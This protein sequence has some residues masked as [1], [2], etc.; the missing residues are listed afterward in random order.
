MTRFLLALALSALFL[1]TARAQPASAFDAASLDALFDHAPKVEV[2]LHGALLRLAASASEDDEDASAML[3]GLRSIVVRVYSLAAARDGLTDRLTSLGSSLEGSGW[4]TL[5]RVRPDDEDGDDVW[6]YVREAGDVFDGMAVMSL[7]HDGGD[8]SFVLI[9][10][11]ID[12]SQVGHLGSR[13]GGVDIEAQDAAEEA[14]QEAHED[15]E[16]AHEEMEALQDSMQVTMDEAMEEA[17]VEMEA[18]R[19][20]MEAARERMERA[21]R[22]AVDRAQEEARAAKP[23]RGQAGRKP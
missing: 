22:D 2:N 15:M 21:R 16:E 12:P 5:V 20:E 9:D 10:G 11:P 13:F 19:V 3:R 17:R 6:V 18:A 1:P 23:E 7:D 4:T 8:A 14:M